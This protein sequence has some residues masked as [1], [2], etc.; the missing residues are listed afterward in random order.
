VEIVIEIGTP[1]Q[2]ELIAQELKLFESIPQ[3]FDPPLNLTKIIITEN[4]DA[5]VNELQGTTS[6]KSEKGLGNNGVST[7]GKIIKDG[8]GYAVVVSPILY[9]EKYD[10]LVRY[11]ILIHELIHVVNKRD[12]PPIPTDSYVNGL[13]THNLYTLYDEYYADRMSYH[14]CD[15]IYPEKSQFWIEH[16]DNEVQGFIELLTDMKYYEAIRSEIESFRSHANVEEFLKVT[17]PYYDLVA[18]VLSHTYAIHHQFPDKIP[19]AMLS[20]SKFVNEKTTKLMEYFLRKFEER[21]AK[22]EDGT[23]VIVD[24]MTNFGVK[25]EH[26]DY[27]GYCHVLDI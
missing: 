26:R 1:E 8:D 2:K 20:K 12:F 18:I 5:K 22:L 14:L 23:D 24:F 19:E 9:T 10:T 11:F 16:L 13:Y 25:F 6:F 15:T 3:Q 21:A 27:G 7:I 4:F 17:N